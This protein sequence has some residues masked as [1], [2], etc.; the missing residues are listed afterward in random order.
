MS[1]FE[2][3]IHNQ[4]GDVD[5]GGGLGCMEFHGVIDFIDHHAAF[6]MF[7][8]IHG[9]DSAADGFGCFGA[10]FAQLGCDFAHFTVGP[11]G[12]VGDPVFG[13]TVDGGDAPSADD[14]GLAL[15]MRRERARATKPGELDSDF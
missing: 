1:D 12:G 11:A 8:D 7:D 9:Q 13:F 3:V 2:G 10:D 5:A 15:S 14:E 4:P 6:G